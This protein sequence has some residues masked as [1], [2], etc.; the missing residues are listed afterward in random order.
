VAANAQPARLVAQSM[1]RKKSQAYL[2]QFTRRPDTA[3]AR[4]LGVHHGVELAYI[5]G[6]MD[7][8]DGYDHTDLGLSNKMMDYWTN[9]AK[10]GNPNGPGLAFW[11]AY[12]SNSD[13]NLEFSDTIQAN[14][15]LFKKECDFISRMSNDR[16]SKAKTDRKG[17]EIWR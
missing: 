8:S 4:K 13:L 16:R 7:K 12:R 17:I 14:K 2:Y 15:H 6:N 5:F 1:E 3:M 10:T 11:P 9:F